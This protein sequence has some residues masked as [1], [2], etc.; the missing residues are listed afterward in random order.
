MSMIMDS[1]LVKLYYFIRLKVAKKA[2]LKIRLQYY[3][4]LGI[5][6]FIF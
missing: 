3:D 4:A 6:Y 2:N 5:I 1:S